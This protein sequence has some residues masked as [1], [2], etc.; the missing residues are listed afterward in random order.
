[1]HWMYNLVPVVD[2]IDS[3]FLLA[4]LFVDRCS[5]GTL[6]LDNTTYIEYPTSQEELSGR[7]E[8]CVDGEFVDICQGGIDVRHVCSYFRYPGIVQK[9]A[10]LFMCISIL[11]FV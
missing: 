2:E 1:M 3:F 4:L 9:S 7:V 5:E 8:V 11:F 6:N 10:K